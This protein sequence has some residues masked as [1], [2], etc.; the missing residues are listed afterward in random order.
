MFFIVDHVESVR[1]NCKS[2]FAF[3]SSDRQKDAVALVN[4]EDTMD[5]NAIQNEVNNNK[6]SLDMS[7]VL[8]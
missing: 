4:L 1:N 7:I 8:I 5:D 3:I 6:E 2:R